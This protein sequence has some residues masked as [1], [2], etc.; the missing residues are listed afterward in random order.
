MLLP[1][2]VG[3]TA[4]AFLTAASAQAKTILHISDVH[5]NITLDQMHYGFD[6]SP[7]L[8]DSALSY[9]RS[10]LRNPDLLLY[11]GDA[12]AH[13]KHNES[14][15]ATSVKAGIDMLES[16]FQVKNVTAILGNADCLH[17]YE[18]YITD[19][20]NGTN[21][22][23]GMVDEPWKKSLT[24]SQFNQ[25]DT[26]GYLLYQIEPKLILI[27]LNTVPY[28]I[29]HSPDT[30]HLDD[31]FDQFVWLRAT[32]DETRRNGSF[33][34][35]TGH[36]PPI[37]D[38]Y[39]GESQWNLKYILSYKAIV[40]DFPDI[41]KAQLF[42]HVHSIEYRVPVE[43]LDGLLGVPLFASGAISPFFGNN[44]SFTIWEYD[45]DTYDLTDFS[46]FAT[47]FSVAG[48][49]VLDWKK[50]FTATTLYNLSSI[51]SKSLRELTQRMKADDTLLHEYYRHSKADTRRLTPC[52]TTDCLDR[53]LCAQTWFESEEEYQ[54][55]VDDRG[56]ERAGAPD[57]VETVP[58]VSWF[59][60]L[61]VS[62]VAAAL[63]SGLIVFLH[64]VLKRS[65]YMSLRAPMHFVP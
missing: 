1:S 22:T 56:L 49:D 23:I 20:K 28:S 38:S 9:A 8:L 46:V 50:I 14:V 34:Y 24:R 62:A 17:D 12:V 61:L 30:K 27:T 10:V 36:I 64:R 26:R 58:R 11:T 43:N 35:I 57:L 5:L 4:V 6:S 59:W 31:P 55:C 15:L 18:F 41:I 25:F 45:A 51:S 19:P 7:R 44:P 42:G 39:K 16:Y 3:W 2:L 37:I 65:T 54:Q 47:N 40:Q 13:T 53:V 63:L 29:K 21:P 52:D 60:A 48:S 32:L 33:A